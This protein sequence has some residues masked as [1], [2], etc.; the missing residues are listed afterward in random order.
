[1]SKQK[2]RSHE[3]L[4]SKNPTNNEC[5]SDKSEVEAPSIQTRKEFTDAFF[6]AMF[7]TIIKSREV[8]PS[9]DITMMGREMMEH[10]TETIA[11]GAVSFKFLMEESMIIPIP[12]NEETID[13]IR[14]SKDSRKSFDN[15]I[16]STHIDIIFIISTMMVNK[17]IRK[18]GERQR[19]LNL[20]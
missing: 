9:I 18:L 10:E 16:I 17:I 1:M 3:S 11:A 19:G 8:R 5:I 13:S 15:S 12:T 6:F 4:V 20:G 14:L 2:G 7:E